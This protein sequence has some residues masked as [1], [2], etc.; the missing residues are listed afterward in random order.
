MI[1]AANAVWTETCPVAKSSRFHL[2]KP[3]VTARGNS[4][5]IRSAVGT[6]RPCAISLVL[7]VYACGG[8]GQRFAE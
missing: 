3:S 2:E 6:G 7:L 1:W 4:P 8:F 5:R